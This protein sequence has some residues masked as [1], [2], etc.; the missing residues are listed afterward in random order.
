MELLNGKASVSRSLELLL[1]RSRL[2][3][4]ELHH[5][6]ADTAGLFEPVNVC[7]RWMVQRRER[8]SLACEPGESFGLASKFVW[9]DFER[10][11]TIQ[12]RI[13][14]A[15]D[16]PH[17]ALADMRNDFV[18]AE[19]GAGCEGQVLQNYVAALNASAFWKTRPAV[20]VSRK[21]RP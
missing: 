16:L 15:V 18:D 17:P 3:L 8:L 6:C 14:S 7:D 10:D 9:Q 11:V 20:S 21:L 5:Q 4:D 12:F 19:P 13:A 2:T 1:L